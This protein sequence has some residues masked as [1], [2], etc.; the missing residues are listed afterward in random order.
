[1]ARSSLS[2]HFKLI[3]FHPLLISYP[4]NQI[5]PIQFPPHRKLKAPKMGPPNEK[6]FLLDIVAEDACA[7][8]LPLKELPNNRSIEPSVVWQQFFGLTGR[9]FSHPLLL[10]HLLSGESGFWTWNLTHEK[11]ELYPLSYGATP[12]NSWGLWSCQ[13]G[14]VPAGGCFK[15]QSSC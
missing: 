9:G 1:M 7:F 4:V 2:S 6:C 8:L 15:P 12:G 11:L 14:E 10:Y 13:L 3:Y 5:A